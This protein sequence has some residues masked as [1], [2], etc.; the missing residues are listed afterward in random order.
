MCV[1]QKIITTKNKR[2]QRTIDKRATGR[3]SSS[4]LGRAS[5]HRRSS[6]L[7]QRSSWKEKQSAAA[8]IALP[9]ATS[10]L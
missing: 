9:A 3:V 1:R 2:D 4:S 6:S 7:Q 10:A 5:Q 8:F